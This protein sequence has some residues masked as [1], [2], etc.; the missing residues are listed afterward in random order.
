MAVFLLTLEWRRPYYFLQDDNRAYSLPLWTLAARSLGQGE[1]AQYNFHQFLGAPLLAAGQPAVLSPVP[2]L[3]LATSRGLFGHP[4]AAVD[5]L[6][7]AYFLLGACGMVVLARQAGM[8]TWAAAFAATAW[9]LLPLNVY[10]SVSWCMVAPLVGLLPWIFALT[11]G[12]MRDPGPGRATALVVCHLALFFAGY[13]PW[14]AY[15]VV[16]EGLWCG[17]LLG[18]GAAAGVLQRRAAVKW[19]ALAALATL[20]LAAPLLAPMA[21]LTQNSGERA[22]RL[23]PE[24][25]AAGS[26]RPLTWL[27]GLIDP[28]TRRLRSP[29]VEHYYTEVGSPPSLP[30][31]GWPALLFGL[32]AVV[33]LARRGALASG[34]RSVAAVCAALAA[35]ALAWSFGWLAPVVTHLPVLNRFRWHFRLLPYF[36]L[37]ALALGGFGLDAARRRLQSRAGQVVLAALCFLQIA[38]LWLLNLRHD[39]RGFLAHSDPLPL[40]EPWRAALA[41]GRVATL[42]NYGSGGRP[43]T[44]RSVGFNYATLWGLF[45][46]GGYEPLLPKANLDATLHRFHSYFAEP[47]ERL[48]IAYLR[49]WGVRNYVLSPGAVAAYDDHLRRHGV[50]QWVCTPER[51]LYIDPAA[52]PLAGWGDDGRAEGLALAVSGNSLVVDARRDRPGTIVLAFLDHPFLRAEID[53]QPTPHQRLELGQIAVAVPAGR[54]EIRLRYVDPFFRFGARAAAGGLALWTVVLVLEWRRSRAAPSDLLQAV[55]LRD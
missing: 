12:L 33:A 15:T 44:V 4:F 40:D 3:A 30:H 37:F 22:T 24:A 2:Y 14:S 21:H 42:G 39:Y 49:A 9:P 51:C 47:P 52:V 55:P 41:K 5:L 50:Q 19:L 18:L 23:A 46:L 36:A 38:G 8:S 43:D 45:Q 25:A 31:L 17:A 16:F 11:L 26:I 1:L 54:H 27:A 29:S 53:G 6:V 20:L 7:A 48:P 10:L 28:F 13:P 34:Q 35:L 32:L